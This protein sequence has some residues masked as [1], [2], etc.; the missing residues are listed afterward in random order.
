MVSVVKL[1]LKLEKKEEYNKKML[2]KNKSIIY[3]K[4][5]QT[6]NQNDTKQKNSQDYKIN[7]KNYKTNTKNYKIN[8]Q[9]FDFKN[10]ENSKISYYLKKYYENPYISFKQVR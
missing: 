2:Q 10:N 3:K 1:M 9:K 8:N 6:K 7:N 4:F 5:K